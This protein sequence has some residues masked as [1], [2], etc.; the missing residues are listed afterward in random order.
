MKYKEYHGSWTDDDVMKFVLKSNGIIK[1]KKSIDTIVSK[2]KELEDY[3]L[4]RF[5]DI[6]DDTY[7]YEIV[8]R[9]LNHIENVR[10]CPCCGKR[11][12]L[13]SSGHDKHLRYTLFCDD[14]IPFSK[15]FDDLE[16]GLFLNR[17][18]P[19]PVIKDDIDDDFILNYII[20]SYN[21]TN[22]T[23]TFKRFER[24]LE[25]IK[26][27]QPYIYDYI[28]NRFDDETENRMGVYI[29]RIM[30]DINKVPKCPICGKPIRH[31]CR[32][33]YNKLRYP[34]FCSNA[35]CT[36]A[37]LPSIGTESEFVEMTLEDAINVSKKYNSVIGL[38][39]S[40]PGALARLYENDMIDECFP[41]REKYRRLLFS[42][43]ID[44]MKKYVYE[45]D[46]RNN[47]PIDI[48]TYAHFVNRATR[49]QLYNDFYGV[50]EKELDHYILTE[51]KPRSY[52]EISIIDNN[53][54]FIKKEPLT[55]YNE[56]RSYYSD[57]RFGKDHE[58][59]DIDVNYMMNYMFKRGI[60]KHFIYN[61]RNGK[62]YA[63][64][65]VTSQ[66][67]PRANIYYA[68]GDLY[69]I[70]PDAVKSISEHNTQ[71]SF[72]TDVIEKMLRPYP[73]ENNCQTFDVN[74]F[75]SEIDKQKWRNR[76]PE[77]FNE[78]SSN[79]INYENKKQLE[80]AQKWIES[81]HCTS[82]Y[83]GCSMCPSEI[84]FWTFRGWTEEYAKKRIEE[85]N[86][87]SFDNWR[88]I[89]ETDPQ[90]YYES[91][92]MRPEYYMKRLSC[93][94]E[95]AMQHVREL[96][97]QRVCTL[98]NCIKRYGEEEGTRR[99]NER[100]EKWMNTLKSKPDFDDIVARKSTGLYSPISQELFDRV[101]EKMEELYPGF[102]DETHVY[103]ATRN[104]EFYI[105][106]SEGDGVLYDFVIS[107]LKYNLEFNG[108]HVHPTPDIDA[109]TG[110]QEKWLTPYGDTYEKCHAKDAM[111]KQLIEDRGYMQDIVWYKEYCEDKN[112]C[113]ERIVKRLITLYESYKNSPDN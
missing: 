57:I 106:T 10:H 41:Y 87:K 67:S 42:D 98:E 7:Y 52:S 64:S 84:G 32:P 92:V 13:K 69:V 47:A 4:G 33:G 85:T 8:Y 18:N 30:N 35:C 5:K 78:G 48:L 79:T 72:Y 26:E 80:I 107:R 36:N 11:I 54:Y 49:G 61:P 86:K 16:I 23:V 45:C 73:F 29:Y 77:F 102:A 9:I 95:E 37:K 28:I 50:A 14:C 103:Y 24:Y 59:I 43:V 51:G 44:E 93:S 91:L 94:Y 71:F 108:E 63:D 100:Q 104:K 60:C 82:E 55:Y 97:K 20:S 101:V 62:Y 56:M 96:Q 38:A 88:K 75:K 22:S 21:E 12:L 65:A 1:N 58:S 70:G 34:V 90:R 109:S 6:D 111:K 89:K 46:F 99:F 74:E 2:N 19:Q 68:N 40:E 15:D 112:K 83:P 3:L 27:V 105:R 39:K 110:L 81:G 25:Y 17:E 53:G 113:I 31:D 66:I 76:Y